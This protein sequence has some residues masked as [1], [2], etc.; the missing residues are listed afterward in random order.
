VNDEDYEGET[1]GEGR[2]FTKSKRKKDVIESRKESIRKLAN[3]N[4]D[5]RR[6]PVVKR[7]RF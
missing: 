5:P 6:S 7:N 3:E 2:L 4:E 1:E